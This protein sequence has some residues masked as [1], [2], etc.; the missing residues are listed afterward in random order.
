MVRAATM[1]AA[2]ALCLLLAAGCTTLTGSSSSD[3]S[4]EKS[5]QK[6]AV[7]VA[8]ADAG[9]MDTS[10]PVTLDGEIK[11]AQEL[12]AKGEYDESLRSLAQLMLFAPDDARVVGDYG[13]VLEQEGRSHE[14]LAFLSRAVELQP[15]NWTLHSAL[16]VAYDQLDDHASA[17]IAYQRALALKPGEGSVLNNFGV[18][19]MLAGDY[20][21]ARKLFAAAEAAGS[22]NPKIALNLD[23]LADLNPAPTPIAPTPAKYVVKSSAATPVQ[24]GHMPV[25]VTVQAAPAAAT[26]PIP[27]KYVVKSPAATPAQG[28]HMPLPLT[29]QAPPPPTT[30][31]IPA[32]YVVKSSAATPTQGSHMPLPVT[33]QAAPAPKVVMQRVPTD[34]LTA[35]VTV[36]STQNPTQVATAAPR[37][38][39]PQVVMQRVPI[40]PLAGPVW[41]LHRPSSKLPAALKLKVEPLTP[42]ETTPSLRTAADAN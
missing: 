19:R 21:Q 8:N 27:A 28:S 5:A 11:R 25:P 32:N 13:K 34:P 41:H 7:H 26:A 31:L 42:A 16:G 15:R 4:A 30:V 40:D 39:G 1:S 17:R 38:L 24:D 20:P 3:K 36:K 14:A 29:I 2:S 9:V 23:K 12:R 18:S 6:P 35:H 10:L 22:P 33:V 37:A